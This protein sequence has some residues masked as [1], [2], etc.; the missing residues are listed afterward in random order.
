MFF[1]VY[2]LQVF[3]SPCW[4]LAF[5]RV[6]V[7]REK[8][9]NKV[10]NDLSDKDVQGKARSTRRVEP[11]HHRII[12]QVLMA[13]QISSQASML[14]YVSANAHAELSNVAACAVINANN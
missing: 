13:K 3:S 12:R 11:H 2:Q 7:H 14:T 10:A 4:Q 1:L 6:R 5:L 8:R 9:S